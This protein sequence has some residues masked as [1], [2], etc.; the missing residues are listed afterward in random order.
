M[1]QQVAPIEIYVK[2]HTK[3][4]HLQST[5]IHKHTHTHTHARTHAH[6]HTHTHTHFCLY[7]LCCGCHSPTVLLCPAN[8]AVRATCFPPSPPPHTRFL[9]SDPPSSVVSAVSKCTSTPPPATTTTPVPLLVT[10]CL[11]RCSVLPR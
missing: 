4:P 5:N 6:T 10:V 9:S 8:G 3:T 1:C 11:I 2:K 7:P